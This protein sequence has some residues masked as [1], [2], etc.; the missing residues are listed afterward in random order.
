VDDLGVDHETNVVGALAVAL[1]DR[2]REATETAADMPASYPAAL[3]SLR[4]WASGKPVDVLTDALK[5]SHSRAVRV[6]DRLVADGFAVRRPSDDDRRAVLVEL[7]PAGRRAA[8]RIS[9]ARAEALSQALS[10]L[11][12]DE[13]RALASLADRLLFEASGGRGD[14][15][16]I[17]RLCDA[18]ACGHFEGRCPVTLGADAAS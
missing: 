15:R 14:A 16:R 13:R 11:S 1:S 7:T 9:A 18:G 2:L 12:A 5:V 10:V 17:C 6:V 4:Q 3:V 8:D